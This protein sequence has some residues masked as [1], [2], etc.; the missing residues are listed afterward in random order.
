MTQG[1]LLRDLCIEDSSPRPLPTAFREAMQLFP[2][3][4][5]GVPC[6]RPL[7]RVYYETAA[8]AD[9]LMELRLDT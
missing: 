1:I 7:G 8:N 2:L 3:G 6:H 5:L 4:L 9:R